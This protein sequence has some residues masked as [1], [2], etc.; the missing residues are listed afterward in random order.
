MS[1]LFSQALVEEYSGASSLGGTPSAPSNTTP[2][3]QAFL[4]RDKTT[5]AWNRFPSGMTCEPL[6]ASHGEAVLMSCLEASLVRTSAPQEREP[7]SKDN[8]VECGNTWHELSVR[9]DPA[10]P[11]WKTHQCLWEEVLPWSSVTLPKWGLMQGGVLWE[12]TPPD[13]VTNANECG[14]L[15]TPLARMWKNR[16]WW[17]REN[18]MGNLDELPAMQP[19]TYG[20]LAGK[21]MSLTW[22]EHHMIFPLGWTD[23]RPL[24]MPKFQQ[25]LRSHGNY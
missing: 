5:D 24:A 16:Y 6:T 4:S 1:W 15:G 13:V 8:E 11:S 25:W 7:E 12:L 17:N 21:Q 3:P 20:N 23:Q 2:T 18:P 9:F 22:L 10:S 14:L 19:Q